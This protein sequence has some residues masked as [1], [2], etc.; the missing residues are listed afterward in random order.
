[1]NLTKRV[2]ELVS[3]YGDVSTK[4]LPDGQILIRINRA[5]LPQNCSPPD[6]DFLMTFPPGQDK[7]SGRYVKDQVR[8][9]SGGTPSFS[10][11]IIDGETWNG[12]SFNFPWEPTDPLYQYVESALHRFAKPN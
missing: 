6:T 11:T 2:E 12:F 8:L 4:T 3:I 9:S 1:M 10:P 5:L 7:P